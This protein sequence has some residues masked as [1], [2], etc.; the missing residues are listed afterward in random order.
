MVCCDLKEPLNKS[1]LM[2]RSCRMGCAK[3]ENLFRGSLN[4][5]TVYRVHLNLLQNGNFLWMRAW[6][7]STLQGTPD[8]RAF[9]HEYLSD[10]GSAW[11][12]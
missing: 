1:P 9:C 3:G 8:D 10:R 7:S 12:H 4:E 11:I 6:C 5:H 2:R